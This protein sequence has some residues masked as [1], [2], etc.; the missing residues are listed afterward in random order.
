M[1]KL[2]G[3]NQIVDVLTPLK[4]MLHAVQIDFFD[5]FWFCVDE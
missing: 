3:F 2:I 5:K 4:T 1:S